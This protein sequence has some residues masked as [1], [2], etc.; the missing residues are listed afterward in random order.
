MNQHP[1]NPN[2]D[3]ADPFA[4]A[5]DPTLRMV[6]PPR[7]TRKESPAAELPHPTGMPVPG[8]KDKENGA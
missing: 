5:N 3:P 7:A 8:S 2:D 6:W 1:T 4:N